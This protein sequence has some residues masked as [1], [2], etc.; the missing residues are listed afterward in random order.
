MTWLVWWYIGFC[1]GLLVSVIIV[2]IMERAGV[3]EETP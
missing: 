3:G 2:G 1:S